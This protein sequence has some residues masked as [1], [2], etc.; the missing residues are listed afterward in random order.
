LEG[1]I[2]PIEPKST[3]E[4][5]RREALSQALP[6]LRRPFSPEAVKYKVQ[7]EWGSGALLVAYIDA[8]LVIERLNAVVG[9]WW[10]DRCEPIGQ[11]LVRGD[12]S[13]FGVTRPDVGVGTG[14]MATK[15][16][17]S[18]ALKRAGVKFGIG[19]SIYALPQVKQNVGAGPD[20]L[21]TQEKNKKQRDGSYK[22][23]P[24]P[25]IDVRSLRFLRESYGTWL[26][27][28]GVPRFGPALD[29]GDVEDA[30]GDMDVDTAPDEQEA[31]GEQELKDDRANA[32]RERAMAVHGLVRAKD[33]RKVP[34]A[35]IRRRLAEAAGSHEA[36]EAVVKWIEVVAVE[37]GAMADE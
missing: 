5:D 10:E 36:L 3:D 16:S 2:L 23:Q 34:P 21:R 17:W 8:R 13:V 11:G 37:I 15:G 29:H 31:V 20:Q 18:D 30:Q 9:G 33:A 12:L 22:K 32:L 7:T 24:V 28:T 19:V 25:V 26:Q 1:E 27:E 14:P 35:D 4:W 6:H